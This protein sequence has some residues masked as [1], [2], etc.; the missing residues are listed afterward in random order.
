[1]ITVQVDM[2]GLT[3]EQIAALTREGEELGFD[4]R[5][6]Y[7]EGGTLEIIGGVLIVL[8]VLKPFFD[9]LQKRFGTAAADW[10]VGWI[11]TLGNGQELKVIE[12]D[13]TGIRFLWD[14]AADADRR[15]AAEAMSKVDLSVLPE[16]AVLRW[17][18]GQW[19]VIEHVT[20]NPP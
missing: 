7:P 18:D 13:G 3:D 2:S 4:V 19:T 14:M 9:A 8:T 11:R 5:R 15:T 10:L 6:L 1:M 16:N 12:C 17:Q 20:P